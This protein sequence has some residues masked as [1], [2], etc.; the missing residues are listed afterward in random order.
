MDGVDI[1]FD[2]KIVG[3]GTVTVL[4]VFNGVL[5]PLQFF[6]SPWLMDISFEEKGKFLDV[7]GLKDFLDSLED[8]LFGEIS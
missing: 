4:D 1:F 2:K 8:F 3:G 7:T 6:L 5:F